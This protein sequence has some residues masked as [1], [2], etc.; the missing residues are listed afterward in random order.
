[1]LESLKFGFAGALLAASKREAFARGAQRVVI[2]AEPDSEAARVYG[3]LGFRTV[4][5]TVNARRV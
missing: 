2:I 4:E 3:R 5:R 1:M